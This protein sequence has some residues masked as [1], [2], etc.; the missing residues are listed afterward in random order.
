M[1]MNS[2]KFFT[3]IALALALS[4]SGPAVLAKDNKGKGGGGGG[5]KGSSSK[6]VKRDSP[7]PAARVSR[8]GSP[9]RSTQTV[10]RSSPDRG[11]GQQRLVRS[12]GP[13]Q[14][15]RRIESSNV[16]PRQLA[17]RRDTDTRRVASAPSVASSST[18]RDRDRVGDRDRDRSRYVTRHERHDHDWFVRN[19]YIYDRDYWHRH[20]VHRYYND[21]LGVFII[22]PFGP[23]YAYGS[24]YVD[25]YSDYRGFDYETRIA[26][27]RA[28]ADLGY[29]N[30]PI[31]GV[32]GPGTMAAIERY[33]ADNGLAIT[34][35]IN[36]SLMQSLDI[37]YQI[38]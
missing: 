2:P 11:S 3:A 24:S 27:Q 13:R 12:Q 15:E 4:L 5:K 19:N 20:H 35:R 28:L 22:S 21:A 16:S 7:R 9:A 36:T 31:D 26:V 33:Q 6:V 29:Y 1:F 30:G 38:Q 18:V 8:G 25:G 14:T 23:S 34:G 32:I 37:L 17:A 10:M